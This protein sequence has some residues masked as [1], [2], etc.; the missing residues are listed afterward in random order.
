MGGV[1]LGD[2]A[3]RG[4][5]ADLVAELGEPEVAVGP[6]R[7]ADRAAA[8]GDAENSVMTPAVVIR[9]ISCSALGEPEVAVG[10]AAMSGADAGLPVGNSVIDAGRGDPADLSP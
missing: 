2:D 9:P 1:E 5:P 4:D 7:D 6:G 3:G 8:G 10:P